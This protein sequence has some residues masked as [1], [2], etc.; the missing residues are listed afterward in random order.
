MSDDLNITIDDLL[1]LEIPVASPM[2]NV[3]I[4]PHTDE[5][6]PDDDERFFARKV[7]T[8]LNQEYLKAADYPP[9]REVFKA[10]PEL[11]SVGKDSVVRILKEANRLLTDIRGL[12]P[13][14]VNVKR[15]RQLDPA[16]VA[17]CNLLANPIDT[18]SIPAKLK[19]VGLTSSKFNAFLKKDDYYE[20]F[21]GVTDRMIDRETFE[22]GRL[23]LAKNV[24]EGD[25]QSFKYF[26][27]LTGK[28][29]GAEGLDGRVI[30]LL[31]ETILTI[32]TRHVD[33]ATA[34]VIAD[35]IDKAAVGQIINANSRELKP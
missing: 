19:D 18:R 1:K 32:I 31:L 8:F 10:V 12:P 24:V 17:A 9:L 5:N 7:V 35:E 33:G 16:F 23:A 2:P 6:I 15:K 11:A 13:Y 25:L 29:R 4:L 3:V 27:E 22:L 21:R 14:H 20:F 30:A 34:R 26:N 28:Y